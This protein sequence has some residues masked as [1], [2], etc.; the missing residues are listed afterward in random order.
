M[1]WRTLRRAMYPFVG[2]L[3]IVAL[4]QAYTGIFEVSRIVLPSPADIMLASMARYDLLLSETWP[5]FLE[6]VCGFGLAMLI[7]VPLA[8][9]T[10]K[11]NEAHFAW[12]SLLPGLLAALML[13]AVLGMLFGDSGSAEEDP[14]EP[15][16]AT[17]SA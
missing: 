5:T 1:N 7:G 8:Y 10:Y 11:L 16:S 17:P 3:I 6:S 14:D 4:W 2:V 12:F 9:L 13:L 15:I